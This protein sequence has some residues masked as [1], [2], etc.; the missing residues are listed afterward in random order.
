VF[1]QGIP[2]ELIQ[3]I[4]NVIKSENPCSIMEISGYDGSVGQ[5][6]LDCLK[7][8]RL[9][10]STANKIRL[11]RVDL[12]DSA[13]FLEDGIYNNIYNSDHLLD[14]DEMYVYDVILI[15]HLF[16]NLTY[17]DAVSILKSLLNK[18]RNQVLVITPV[19]PYDLDNED[20]LSG[21]RTYHPVAFLGFDF[22]YKLLETDA[23]S[24]QVYSFFPKVKYDI[25]QCDILPEIKDEAELVRKLK[26]AYVIPHF[27]LTGSV[28][29]MLQQM[30]ELAKNGHTIIAYYRSNETDRAIPGWSDLSSDDISKEIVIPD[31]ENYPDH[32][33][34]VDIIVLGWM[35]QVPEFRHSTIPVVL[36]EQG[37]EMFFGDYKEMQDSKA[38][39]R[40]ALH[41]VFRMPVHLLAVSIPV[42]TV[43]NDVYNRRSQL[44]PLNI[45]TDFY[46]PLEKKNNEVP[47]ILLV[48]KPTLPFKG[49]D[50][51]LY[52]LELVRSAGFKYKLIWA[53]PIEYSFP[54]ITFEFE[55]YVEPSQE[56]LAELFRSADIYLSTSLYE[57][58]SLP[59]LEAMA[60]GTAVVATD[61]GGINTYAK[62]GVNCLLCEQGDLNSIAVALQYLLQ[63]PEIRDLLAAEGRKTAL[64]YSVGNTTARLEQCL[65]RILDSE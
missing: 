63:N 24:L 62:P 57:S 14:I 41:T 9:K 36:W 52:A 38:L 17:G 64:E 19:Y 59:P 54:G 46:Y 22:S 30:K 50:A 39:D 18:V 10:D 31:G 58:F 23:D 35:Y 12:S 53:T 56:K 47:V 20:K 28:K 45:D 15:L 34:D 29:A 60:S 13:A 51:A 44:F 43:L 33:T 65:F 21:V 3:L 40:I 2:N 42:K 49:F 48:G 26:I 11:D 5:L 37:S 6:I 16:E 32:I 4:Q 55:K 27:V 8:E 61:N 7:P 25:L 1:L